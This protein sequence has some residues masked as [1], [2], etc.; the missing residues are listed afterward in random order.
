MTYLV[1]LPP[2]K[3]KQ[4]HAVIALTYVWTI[5]SVL[6]RPAVPCLAE[7]AARIGLG[8]ARIVPSTVVM[9]IICSFDSEIPLQP[10]AAEPESYTLTLLP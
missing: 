9:V 1:M 5:V 10:W 4:A 2:V 7:V 8:I 3:G 6:H